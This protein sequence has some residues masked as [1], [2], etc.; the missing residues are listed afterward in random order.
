MNNLRAIRKA[1]RLAL[2]GLAARTGVSATTLSAIERWDY[3]PGPDVRHRIAVALGVSV[4]DVWPG[5]MDD[6]RQRE[7]TDSATGARR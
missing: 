2:W 1:Q 4:A 7:A 5:P 6:A 3:M